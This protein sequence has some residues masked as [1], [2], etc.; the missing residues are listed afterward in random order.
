MFDPKKNYSNI[1]GN[2]YELLNQKLSEIEKLWE[3]VETIQLSGSN[4]KQILSEEVIQDTIES[5]IQELSSAET[6]DDQE[7]EETVYDKIF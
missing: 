1:V 6:T 4:R 7:L 3:E 2:K 5:C